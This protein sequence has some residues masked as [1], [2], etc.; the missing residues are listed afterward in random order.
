MISL[1]PAGPAL[2]GDPVDF[3]FPPHI[4][5]LDKP[6]GGIAKEIYT[7][8]FY[9]PDVP[10]LLYVMKPDAVRKILIERAEYFPLSRS[11]LNILR[12]IWRT[13][14]AASEGANWRRQRQTAAPFFTPKAAKSVI[15]LAEVAARLLIARWKTSSGPTELTSD[16][17]H[18]MSAVTWQATLG[19]DANDPLFMAQAEASRKL[20]EDIQRLNVSD[21]LQLPNWTRRFCGPTSDRSAADLRT[22]VE[23]HLTA[24]LN[25]PEKTLRRLLVL[26][27]DVNESGALPASQILDNLVGMLA[28]GR[29][30]TALAASWALWLIANCPRTAADIA[31]EIG[32]AGLTDDLQPADFE[33]LPFLKAVVMEALRLFPP[34]HQIM[35]RCSVSTD[36]GG[37]DARKG[38]TV[39]I[40]VY[41]LH[42]R[43]DS[44]PQPLAFNPRRFLPENQ[45]A[46]LLRNRYL[47]FG[48]GPRICNGMHMALIEIQTLVATVVRHANVQ[49]DV[50]EAT[51]TLDAGFILRPAN[52]LR[53]QFEWH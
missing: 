25:L 14:L 1:P 51:V 46:H 48:S 22:I 52:G 35:R 24:N 40:P 47:P 13:G 34:A 50:G 28:A 12:P 53:V 37:V 36:L 23:D 30:T 32:A 27:A 18:A 16:I 43:A 38:D 7:D 9:R 15:P 10:R 39:F 49:R 17:S 3:L 42:R 29:E 45:D 6:L 11:S 26:A 31:D 33:K 5:P 41:A 21:M 20:L 2:L 44:W 19:V 8:D 4:P